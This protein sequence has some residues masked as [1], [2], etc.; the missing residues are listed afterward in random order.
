VVVSY[1]NAIFSFCCFSQLPLRNILNLESGVEISL[2]ESIAINELKSG[3]VNA[4]VF[5]KNVP[6]FAQMPH[7]ECNERGE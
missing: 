2:E 1:A 5:F 6:I 7:G 3:M 4:I